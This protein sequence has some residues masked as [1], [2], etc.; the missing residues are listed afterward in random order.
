MS[1]TVA[2]LDFLEKSDVLHDYQSGSCSMY[3]PNVVQLGWMGPVC[4]A[5][6]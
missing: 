1:A 5:K 6:M 2:I 4:R 3:M